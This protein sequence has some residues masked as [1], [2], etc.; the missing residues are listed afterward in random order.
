[1]KAEIAR[2]LNAAA[3]S[4]PIVFEWTMMPSQ[5]TGEEL[6]LT[7]LG[8]HVKYEKDEIYTVL[9]PT[10]IAVNHKQQFKD[11]YKRGGWEAVKAYHRGVMDKIKDKTPVPF[12][13]N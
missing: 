8:D 6:N 12:N 7:P 13:L 11:A 1:M 3:E 10:M 9:M 5:F 2:Q 4:T